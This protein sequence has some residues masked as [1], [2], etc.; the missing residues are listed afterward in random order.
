MVF[1]QGV[2]WIYGDFHGQKPNLWSS[3]DCL[4][5]RNSPIGLEPIAGCRI[6][7]R[8][9][10]GYLWG[11]WDHWLQSAWKAKNE[12]LQNSPVGGCLGLYYPLCWLMIGM[13]TIHE[14]G[15]LEKPVSEASTFGV[16][17]TLL[18]WRKWGWFYPDWGHLLGLPSMK[19]SYSWWFHRCCF[20]SS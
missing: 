1:S 16:R 7:F 5:L 10:T 20:L 3:L 2:P 9:T 6:S 17:W 19:A 12:W 8:H 4:E 18:I 14:L 11:D 13:I 15:I